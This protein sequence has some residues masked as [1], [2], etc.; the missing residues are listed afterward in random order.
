MEVLRQFHVCLLFSNDNSQFVLGIL[1]QIDSMILFEVA[2]DLLMKEIVQFCML[3]CVN[4]E[5]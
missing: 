1:H 2:L 4:I 3:H 5:F